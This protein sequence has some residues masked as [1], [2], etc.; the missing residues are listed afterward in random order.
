[1][2]ETHAELNEIELEDIVG[3]IMPRNTALAQRSYIKNY[4]DQFAKKNVIPFMAAAGALAGLDE[5][6]GR[7]YGEIALSYMATMLIASY[8]YFLLVKEF[9][10]EYRAPPR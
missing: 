6:M 1:M 3:E 7:H 8:G 9:Y 4:V 5:L 2:N 10:Q